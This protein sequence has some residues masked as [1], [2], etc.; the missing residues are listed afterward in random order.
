MTF[1]VRYIPALLIVVVSWWL[2]SQSVPVVPM[3]DFDMG[4][5]VVHCVCYAGLAFW[6][7]YALSPRHALPWAIV[8]TM[9]Y[10]VLDECH[11]AFVPGRSCELLD[12]LADASGAVLG[13]YAYI[14][15]KE[16]RVK[17]LRMRYN[18]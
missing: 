11:Q 7:S 12:W 13:T 5:K 4:D 2:S 3:P 16:V 10:G 18:N 15:C 9:L 6:L 14:L 8:L 1:P 17:I